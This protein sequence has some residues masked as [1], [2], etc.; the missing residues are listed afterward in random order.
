M[1]LKLVLFWTVV[2]KL[3]C[4]PGFDDDSDACFIIITFL[5]LLSNLCLWVVKLIVGNFGVKLVYLNFF[6]NKYF[7]VRNTK[8]DYK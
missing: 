2:Y 7:H 6:L 4:Y 3:L 8:T 1:R 5:F